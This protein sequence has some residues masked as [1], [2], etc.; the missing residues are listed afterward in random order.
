LLLG[1]QRKNVIQEDT[2]SFSSDDEQET[3]KDIISKLNFSDPGAAN[4]LNEERL[5][6]AL[7]E[8]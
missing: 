4:I 6:D 3:T 1:F 2:G 5:D 8:F 7:E